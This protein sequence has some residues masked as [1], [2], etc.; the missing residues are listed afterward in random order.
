M[1]LCHFFVLLISIS[2]HSILIL[3]FVGDPFT[4]KMADSYQYTLAF[5]TGI[6]SHLIYFN[7]GEHHM[8]GVRYLQAFLA[9]SFAS[10]LFLHKAQE[11]SLHTASTTVAL[12][13]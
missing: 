5:G 3:I 13:S 11:Q 10:F 9:L 12:L 7:R 8:Y 4:S 2:C 1:S 6:T